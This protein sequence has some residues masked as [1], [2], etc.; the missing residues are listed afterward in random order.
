MVGTTCVDCRGKMCG[1]DDDDN[2]RYVSNPNKRE[3]SDESKVMKKKPN[4]V[5]LHN[6]CFQKK[7]IEARINRANESREHRRDA[8]ENN[9]TRPDETRTVRWM[10]KVTGGRVYD[11]QQAILGIRRPACVSD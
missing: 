11:S 10:T 8:D 7:K 3:G 6:W 1:D 5:Q 9:V 2:N 4:N